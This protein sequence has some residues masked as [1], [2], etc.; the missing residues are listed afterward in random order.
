MA[1]L[2]YTTKVPAEKTVALIM[3]KLVEFGV[4]NVS[5]DYD[6]KKNASGIQFTFLLPD[7][8]PLLFRLEEN[9]P[10]VLK[11]L[12]NAANVPQ[13]LCTIE[14]ARNVAWRIKKDFI[15]AQL[16]LVEAGIASLPEMFIG[17]LVDKK[18]SRLIEV[19]A[20]NSDHFLLNE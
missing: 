11:A 7:G 15:E 4:R 5:L 20:Q 6:E 10:G 19:F 12:N 3:Q 16:A 1:I 13:K 14:H 2:N 8:K 17:D 18:G 9:S